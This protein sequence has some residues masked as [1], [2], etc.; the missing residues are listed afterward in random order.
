MVAPSATG[1]DLPRI[2]K[3]ES[4]I[5]DEYLLPVIYKM[6]FDVSSA[7][8]ILDTFPQVMAFAEAPY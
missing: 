7:E 1:F 6:K 4:S 2:N 3:L 8:L 5:P